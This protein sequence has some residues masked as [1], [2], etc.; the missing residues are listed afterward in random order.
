MKITIRSETEESEEPTMELWLARMM[1]IGTIMLKGKDQDGNEW[2]LVE[3]SGDG[4]HLCDGI[5]AT[6]WPLDADGRLR[7][8]S[9]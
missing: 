6:G 7:V 1:T 2:S 9:G 3:L 8:V 4:I 5:T